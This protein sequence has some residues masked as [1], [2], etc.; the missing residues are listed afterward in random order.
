MRVSSINRFAAAAAI[1]LS[2]ALA[3]LA[4]SRTVQ[5]NPQLSRVSSAFRAMGRFIGR[6]LGP[7]VNALPTVPIPGFDDVAAN[8]LPTVPIPDSGD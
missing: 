7:V 4:E 5:P 8:A 6:Y 2:L 3:P 1:T